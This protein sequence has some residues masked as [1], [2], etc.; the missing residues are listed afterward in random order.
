MD[1]RISELPPLAGAD[2]QQQDV[3][4]VADVSASETKKLTSKDLVQFGVALIDDETIPSTKLQDVRHQDIAPATAA[5]QFLAGPTDAAGRL[6]ARRIDPSDLPLATSTTI[7]GISTGA[8]L[9]ADGA[10]SL[11]VTPATVAA[12]GGVIIDANG[13][14]ETDTS[15]VLR[16]VNNA[17]PPGTRSGIT[18]DEWGHINAAV[19]LVSSDLPAATTGAIGGVSV[20][21]GSGLTVSGLGALGHSNSVTAQT[22]SGISIDGQGHVTALAPIVGTDLPPATQSSLGAVMVPSDGP[23]TISG[24][25]SL[26]HAST[27][28]TTG[29]FTKVTV[30]GFGHVTVGRSLEAADIPD[31]DASKITTG[32]LNP[33][34]LAGLQITAANLYDYSIA[35]IQ[36]PEPSAPD[37]IGHLWLQESSSQLRMWNGNSWMPCGFGAVMANNIRFAGTFNAA[38]GAVVNVT[39]LGRESSF[40]AGQ[41]I[42]PP[43]S[44]NA[45][46][47]FVA[48]VAGTGVGQT[49]GTTYDVGDWILSI[50]P[51][52]S[53][54]RVDMAGPGGGGGSTNLD[55]LT[56]VAVV[57]PR[58]GE[59]LVY[60]TQSASW[61]NGTATGIQHLSFTQQ[62]QNPTPGNGAGQLPTGAIAINLNAAQPFLAIQDTTGAIRRFGVA[63][64]TSAPNSPR[65]G[66]LWLD[67][68]STPVLR[69]W[70]G[71]AWST[72]GAS[73]GSGFPSGTRMLFVQSDAPPGWVRDTTHN[74]KALRIVSGTAGSG[75]SL[76][77][78]TAFASRTVSGS[79]GSTTLN[80]SQMP[81]H[82]H[83]VNDPGHGHGL[84]DAGHS[85]NINDPGHAHNYTKIDGEYGQ[86]PTT[87]QNQATH[88][89]TLIERWIW[90]EHR[91][92]GISVNAAGTNM[93]VQGSGTGIQISSSGGSQGHAHTLADASLDLSVAYVDAIIA[94]KQ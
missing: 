29:T 22:R 86:T 51:Q 47:Y 25:G 53:W 27:T 84:T 62:G 39:P 19:A 67:T 81:A 78:T 54:T 48:V 4:A 34:L 72:G 70:D 11:S 1:L 60:D 38:T 79:T 18:Y 35:F 42:P 89:R 46:C 65:A 90:N 8:G 50:D 57:N 24:T 92:T 75:G 76:G 49:P 59:V 56:D 52:Q 45:G 12:I 94:V 10:G 36:E 30:D 31:L 15:G 17:I 2:L 55:G 32:I 83:G 5:G 77:F 7:G 85:H 44:L 13:G 33:A 71:S 63:V 82:I 37:F 66:E 93:S 91:F 6:T 26:R 16:H 88:V 41:T 20:P 28:A 23:L 61:R 69:C 74:N 3:V 58:A 68:S 80:A 9:A 64:G 43:T 14:L 73:G 21:P 40:S 87:G